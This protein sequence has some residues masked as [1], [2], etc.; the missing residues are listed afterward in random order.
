MSAE[1]ERIEPLAS[2]QTNSWFHAQVTAVV[3][4][5]DEAKDA[6]H[7]VESKNVIHLDDGKGSP[8]L[9]EVTEAPRRLK[10]KYTK[11]I[12]RPPE[13][14]RESRKPVMIPSIQTL[15]P[16][17]AKKN[18]F[19]PV[20]AKMRTQQTSQPVVSYRVVLCLPAPAL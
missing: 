6:S 20:K 3:L 12:P 10:R 5:L 17:Q 11:K 9:D 2:F 4:Q 18:S 7:Q 1:L 15:I 19:Q 13:V 8:R 14:G 16:F